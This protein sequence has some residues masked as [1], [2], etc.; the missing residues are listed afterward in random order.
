M[1]RLGEIIAKET[2]TGEIAP[3]EIARLDQTELQKPGLD[4]CTRH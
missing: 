2:A 4:C 1:G 3:G